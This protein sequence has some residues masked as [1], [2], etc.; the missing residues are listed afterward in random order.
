MDCKLVN[1]L[2]F[3]SILCNFDCFSL[4]LFITL[5]RVKS[6]LLWF[7]VLLHFESHKQSYQLVSDQ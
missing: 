4:S 1:Q 6:L 7:A 2:V 3:E 5:V